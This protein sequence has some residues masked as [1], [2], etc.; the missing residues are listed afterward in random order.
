MMWDLMEVQQ[1]GGGRGHQS[2]DVRVNPKLG[3][4]LHRI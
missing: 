3:C 2:C 1:Y 4:G